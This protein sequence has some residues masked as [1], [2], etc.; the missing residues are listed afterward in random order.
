MFIQF[1][2][3]LAAALMMVAGGLIFLKLN[4]KYPQSITLLT[5]L[6]GGFLLA[7]IFFGI[8][9]E[10]HEML[11]AASPQQVMWLLPLCVA[12]GAALIILFE[13]VLPVQHHHDLVDHEAEHH[14]HENLFY[15]VLAAFGLHSLFELSLII[16]F[17]KVLPVQHH[18][19]LVDHE[20]EHHTHENLFY[21]V[22]AAFGLHSLFELLSVLIAGHADLTMGLLLALV[23]GIHNIPIGFIIMA[24]LQA[25]GCPIKR[26]IAGLGD[27]SGH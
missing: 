13:K 18:H 24:Q 23:I 11:E 3:C 9:P 8:I 21:I 19:D 4:E 5:G 27:L 22:L 14:T 10:A 2:A 26:I 12:A 16:L 7:I 1:I 20:A 25:V 15:I 6:S 17:E